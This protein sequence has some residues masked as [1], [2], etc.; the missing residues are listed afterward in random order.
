[1]KDWPD[2]DDDSCSGLLIHLEF[3]GLAALIVLGFV[4]GYSP[5]LARWFER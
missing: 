2:P 3:W 5:V 1:M 4:L